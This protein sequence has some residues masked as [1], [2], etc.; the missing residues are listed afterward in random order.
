MLTL[1]GVPGTLYL[2][3]KV[4]KFMHIS[5]DSS[6]L[7]WLISLASI[8]CMLVRPRGIAEAYWV[9]AG[10]ILLIVTGLI[11]IHRAAHAVYEGLDVYLFLAGMMILA[12]LAREEHVFEWVADL[13][14]RHA[15]PSPRRLFVLVYL[16]GAMVTA[17]LSNDAT[18]VVL[19]PAVLAVVRRANV[20]PKPYLLACALIAN[21]ASFVF[22]ISNPANLVVFD[23]RMPHLLAWLRI[24]MLPSIVSVLLTF[25][26]L[27]WISRTD[28]QGEYHGALKAVPLSIEGKLALAGLLLAGAALITS[29]ALGLSLGAPTCCAALVAVAIVAWRDHAVPL[30]AARGVSWSILPLVAGLFVIVE[31]LRATGLLR[32]ALTGLQDLAQYSVWMAKFVAAFVVALLSNGMNNLPVGLM[33][34]TA[35]RYS[36]ENGIIA[37]AI[38]IG[39]DLGPNLSVTG[40]LATI[41]WLIALRRENVEITAWDFLKA[42]ALAMP[43]ALAGSLLVLW[44]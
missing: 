35:L 28:L 8:V 21:A 9:G 43:I 12:E 23:E 3:P 15:R 32:L 13:A 31:A 22:P 24:F 26:C 42:G 44:R 2:R 30:R 40:S 17:L 6:V 25:L 19:T 38:L 7:I 4:N 36:H 1:P 27:R 10:A 18:A 16:V 14:A 33:A 41:L 20:Q 29:S 11:A 37:N 5:H 34:G 39:V